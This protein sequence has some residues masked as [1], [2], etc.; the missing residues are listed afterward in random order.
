[1]DSAEPMVLKPRIAPPLTT[2]EYT[3][4]LPPDS[5]L[6]VYG[7]KQDARNSVTAQNLDITE[8][9]HNMLTPFI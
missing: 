8:F 1:M 9:E 6:T 4:V 5:A 2:G 3:G 7:N